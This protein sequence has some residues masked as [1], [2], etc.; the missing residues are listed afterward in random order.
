MN[1]SSGSETLARSLSAGTLVGQYE[2]VS[3]I[4]AGGMG[5][6]YR[7]H[8]QRVGRD[9]A[10]KII[11]SRFG[12]DHDRV[13][14]FAQEART[15]ARVN[16][17]NIVSMFDVGEHDGRPFIVSELLEGE[18]LRKYMAREGRLPVR[19]VVE[20]G[21]QMV[22]ALAAAHE[23]EIVHRDLK[24]ANVFITKDEHLKILDFGLA[25]L[26]RIDWG[27]DSGS[28]TISAVSLPGTILGSAGYMSP[29]QVEARPI[30]HRSDIFSLGVILY[31]MLS[32]V[33]AFG[34]SSVPA[35]LGAI[36]RD[37]PR[38]VSDI[39][40]DVPTALV[41]IIR[42]CMEKD[43]QNRFQSARDLAFSLEELTNLSEP[44]LSSM[45]RSAVRAAVTRMKARPTISIATAAVI[46]VAAIG[47][48]AMNS[49]SA[50]QPLP[51]GTP[52]SANFRLSRITSSG[53]AGNALAV[54]ADAKYALY[55]V[56]GES[57]VRLV[58]LPTRSETRVGT[59]S[60]IHHARFTPDGNY[61]Y[62]DR[63]QDDTQ[64]LYRM[65]I[66]GGTEQMISRNVHPGS[67]A[68]SHDG[69]RISFLRSHQNKM[70]L[71]VGAIDGSEERELSR[72]NVFIDCTWGGNT[73]HLLCSVM[74]DLKF[75]FVE[76]NS[77][78][79]A[80]RILDHLFVVN[81]P[82]VLPDSGDLIGYEQTELNLQLFRVDDQSGKPARITNDL[83]EY[84][85]PS[86]S[87]D[88][89][90]IAA[91]RVDST[92][93]LW[94]VSVENPKALRQITTGVNT[95][96]GNWGLRST[97]DGRI[98]WASG[99][100]GKSVDL[101][102]CDSD[103]SNRKRLTLDDT[104]DE[105]WLDVSPDGRSIV[106]V[107]GQATA[108]ELGTEIWRMNIDGSDP[109]RL[110][111]SEGGRIPRFASDGQTVIFSKNDRLVEIPLAGGPARQIDP[112]PASSPA[113]S[114]DGK[115]LLVV[116]PGDKG[117]HLELWSRDGSTPPRKFDY[118][119]PKRWRPDGGAFVFLRGGKIWIQELD[120]DKPRQLLALA[121]GS[122]AFF[123]VEWSRDS[124]EIIFSRRS[125]QRD[126]ALFQELR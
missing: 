115:W 78:T 118:S 3:F 92:T 54:S 125:Q 33:R 96:D 35:T 81:S 113:P 126:I 44:S 111:G 39:R 71:W 108:P 9:V 93:N 74:Y 6:V 4:G 18:T 97:P 84:L 24:P 16:H 13:R 106:Y 119:G 49:G 91:L 104:A 55:T 8:D 102:I 31:E 73:S 89:R 94:A 77:T 1:D 22:R 75:K 2:I 41:V 59:P 26:A 40:S 114:P 52:T 98:V 60:P 116:V 32:G 14:R 30:D 82:T 67:F 123:G 120:E 86:V 124:K 46:I 110:A 37:Q 47:I 48:A 12:K 20:F 103:G 56:Q 5:E 21:I 107:R 51:P 76:V 27:R 80:D 43:A 100:S 36:L 87:R 83:S 121:D 50:E 95:W 66:L 42:R 63:W 85:F 53:K 34:G 58:H 62:Y 45:T 65:P 64:N 79:G 105:S 10:I 61:I 70:S 28:D 7:A 57:A 112:R 29:E 117:Q 88:G 68:I 69:G 90:T 15:M 11:P 99:A 101:W 19:Q 17:P 38:D 23:K 122:A 72:K 109:V 25:K